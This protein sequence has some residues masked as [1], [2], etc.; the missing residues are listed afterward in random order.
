MTKEIICVTGP[1][2]DDKTL[3]Y[4]DGQLQKE[5]NG[6]KIFPM[7]TPVFIDGMKLGLSLHDEDSTVIQWNLRSEE[8]VPGLFYWGEGYASL[9]YVINYINLYN[10]AV[11]TSMIE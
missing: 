9:N 2:V 3:I 5:L 1:A 8:D 6:S 4:V 10:V 11:S 7:F